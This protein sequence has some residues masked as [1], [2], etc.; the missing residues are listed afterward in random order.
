MSPFRRTTRP[1]A[2]EHRGFIGYAVAVAAT[3]LAT[4][5]R[6]GLNPWL[7]NQLPFVS[8]FI[9]VL[10][11]VWFTRA[12]GPAVLA[13]VLGVVATRWSVPATRYT[14]L[15]DAPVAVA[16][17]SFVLVAGSVIVFGRALQRA[18]KRAETLADE[19]AEQREQL[20]VTLS[21]IGDAV[22]VADEK[23]RVAY[24]NPVAEALTGWS[25]VDAAGRHVDDVFRI[26]SEQH[27]RPI[28]S[29]FTGALRDG[30]RTGLA[31]HTLLIARDGT[32]R[33][34][35]DT[36]APIRDVHGELAGAVLVFRDV[37]ER[38]LADRRV[39]E[40]R[41]YAESIVET[42]REP[43]MILDNQLRVVTANRSF[44][45]KFELV[46]SE[47]QG[48]FVYELGRGEWDLPR[49]RDL[50]ENILVH[51]SGFDDFE[52][53]RSF[54]HLGQRTML[55]NARRID[56][57][58]DRD[59]MILL[60]IE[61]V[62]GRRRIERA[63]RES[64]ERYR[65]IVEGATGFALI[66][67]DLD[68]VVISWNVGA[69]RLMGYTDSE[70][71]GQ[72][73][74][75]FYTSEDQ[76]AGVP[77]RELDV[78]ANNLEGP[79]DNWLVR[80]D[81][82]CFWASGATTG[83][84]DERGILRGFTKVVRDVT[85]RRRSDEALREADRRK[86]EF[87]A[88]LAHELRNPLAPVRNALYIMQH[89]KA[90]GAEWQ[91]ARDVIDRQVR[92]MTRLIDDLLEVSRI[93]Q[94]RMVLQRE[95]VELRQVLQ[96]SIETS[97]PL[98]ERQEQTLNVRLPSEPILIDG[99][100]ARLAQVFANLLDNAAKYQEP[101]GR[102]E[103]RAE[104]RE[105]E[106]VVSIR[107]E[108]IG[109]SP[110]KLS[111]VFEMFAQVES[112]V[113]RSQGGLGIGLSLVKR[114]TD[115]HGGSVDALSDGLGQGST[116]IVRLPIMRHRRH[117]P[118]ES[119]APA[120]AVPAQA[121]RVLVVDDN[122]DAASTVAMLLE[123]RGHEVKTAHDGEQAL[124]VA[125]DFK[126]DVVLLDIGLPKMNGYDVCRRLREQSW[127]EGLIV[128]ALTGWGQTED[129]RKSEVAGFDEH[130]VKPVDPEVLMR[131]LD[132][133]MFLESRPASD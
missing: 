119:D 72:H 118:A 63:L 17:A 60:A 18:R 74:S 69:E 10:A 30:V 9:A 111:H 62:T 40:A 19:Y 102:I 103:L 58:V 29:P 26:V 34:V 73:F 36:A 20:R 81:G 38:R 125:S 116:F 120:S 37:T 130:L 109:I 43:I 44:Y 83:L 96:Q 7:G 22:M 85:E 41:A 66:M 11:V 88:T 70:I 53:E 122:Q 67:L 106:A 13:L 15:V 47:T 82:S 28:E 97:R 50:L 4:A 104:I 87:L 51:D 59:E 78:A 79:D 123:S 133:P 2:R 12:T 110:D 108:G 117:V 127:S 21:S 55:L 92:Q 107:D 99:D 95:P 93:S 80:K 61:D 56:R 114:I 24:L 5:A 98:I 121:R 75:R 1:P 27:R 39:A 128:V 89:Q 94:G 112:A 115:L 129:R 126:P 91:R 32:E 52:V 25:H 54:A 45:R 14:M 23:G 57:E 33:S 8:F 90:G 77:Q 6:F 49:L 35:D 71:L 86:D 84:R 113:D 42:V 105:D 124:R 64:E 100:P 131:L 3:A 48:Q 68:G 76:A 132:Q 46:P 65:L 16:A 101:R 31:D